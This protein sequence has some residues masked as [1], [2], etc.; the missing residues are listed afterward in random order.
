M[1]HDLRR[2]WGGRKGV[3][4]THPLSESTPCVLTKKAGVP[5]GNSVKLDLENRSVQI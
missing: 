4:V 1:M 2:Q 5:A 3:L